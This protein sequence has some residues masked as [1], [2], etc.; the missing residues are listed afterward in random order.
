METT[1]LYVELIVIGLES[2]IWIASFLLY[3]TDAKYLSTVLELLDKIPASILLLGILYAVGMVVDRI[4]D[5]AFARMEEGVRSRAGFQS[6]SALLI[7]KN[8]EDTF[9]YM[10]S[11]IRILRASSLNFPV[12][13]IALVMN[14]LR[15]APQNKALILFTV[16][17]GA[18][19]SAFSFVGYMQGVE[20]QYRK[21]KF[22]KSGA[23]KESGGKKP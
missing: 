4:A 18:T 23:K 6:G 11:K 22:L 12:I 19:F 3:F 9:R 21:A 15:Y 20:N 14:L 2:S 8:A 17:T 7:W 16:A 5:I 1:T 13:T 10:R